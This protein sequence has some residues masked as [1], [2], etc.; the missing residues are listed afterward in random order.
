VLVR[1]AGVDLAPWPS[2]PAYLETVQK[3]PSV[4][5]ALATERALL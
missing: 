2:L 4:A 1:F 3:R 5:E